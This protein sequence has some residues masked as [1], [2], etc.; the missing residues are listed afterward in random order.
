MLIV[1]SLTKKTCH[2]EISSSILQIQVQQVF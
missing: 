1:K 2:T